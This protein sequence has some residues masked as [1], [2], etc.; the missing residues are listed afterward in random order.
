MTS[1][2][3]RQRMDER[4]RLRRMVDAGTVVILK[5]CD[6]APQHQLRRLLELDHRAHRR[7]RDLTEELGL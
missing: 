6:H 2:E 1:F 4:N 3:R 5:V 7:I